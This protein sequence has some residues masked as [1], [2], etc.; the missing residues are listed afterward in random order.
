MGEA[1]EGVD[2]AAA[3]GIRVRQE[4]AVEGARGAAVSG[5]E[6]DQ[7]LLGLGGSVGRLGGQQAPAGVRVEQAQVV[8]D[9]M[10]D[11]VA[12]V[13]RVPVAGVG[14]RDVLHVVGG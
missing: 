4:V 2:V 3:V 14:E 5:G 12:V 9:F 6:V 11:E 10:A 13:G 1:P 8:A 7:G